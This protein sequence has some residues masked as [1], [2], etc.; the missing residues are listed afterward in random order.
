MAILK[1]GGLYYKKHDTYFVGGYCPGCGATFNIAAARPEHYLDFKTPEGVRFNVLMCPVC[2]EMAF[3]TE[4][5]DRIVDWCLKNIEN[6][7]EMNTS[8]E[9]DT[10]SCAS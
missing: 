3:S 4:G 9:R 5:Y 2:A 6:L 7:T 1:D 8:N 10:V